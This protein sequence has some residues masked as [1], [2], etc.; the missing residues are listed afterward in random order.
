MFMAGKHYVGT[1]TNDIKAVELAL[2]NRV[3]Q[4]G[5]LTAAEV[6]EY[7]RKVQ[8]LS[9]GRN[10]VLLGAGGLPSVMVRLQPYKCSEL[11]SGTGDLPHPAFI[12]AN[13]MKPEIFVAKYQ[14]K[15]ISIG[16]PLVAYAVSLR[17]VDPAATIDHTNSKAAC[18]NNG[19][20]WHMITNAEFAFISLLARKR[21]F[22]FRGNNNYGAACDITSEV[23][24]PGSMDATR[25]LHTLTGSGPNTWTHDGTPFGVCDLNGNVWEWC[26]GLRAI[27]GEIQII[28][29]N[30]AADKTIDTG[31]S[32]ALWKA[33]AAADG[34][35]V[36]PNGTG[37]TTGALRWI[38]VDTK[39]VLGSTTAT[40]QEVSRDCAFSNVGVQEGVAAP[41][42]LKLLA[43][44]PEG[45]LNHVGR[46]YLNDMLSERVPF[47]GGTYNITS[48]AGPF[49]LF[50]SFNRANTNAY[51]GFRSAFVKL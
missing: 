38:W 26:Q 16:S 46:F 11:I 29:N 7:D 12:V 17:G 14:A 21:G 27:G 35:L 22:S 37:T 25:V 51:F 47:R 30:D 40:L 13:A 45:T 15:V 33:I 48:N 2:T 24:R 31:A 42:L 5:A 9:E 50:L 10:V 49:A 18:D 39:W 36:A 32:S 41:N 8:E 3:L 44:H 20:G 28:A 1:I 34:A 43:L 6:N 19:T 4:S 23:G